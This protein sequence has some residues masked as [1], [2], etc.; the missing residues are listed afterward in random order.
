MADRGTRTAAWSFTFNNPGNRLPVYDEATMEYLVF[1]REI[2]PETGTPH[3]QGYVRFKTRIFMPA[4]LRRLGLEGVHVEPARGTE[5]QNRDY[6]TKEESRDAGPW[7]FGNFSADAGRRGTRSDLKQATDLIRS[8][9]SMKQVANAHPETFVR[10]FAG[11]QAL[12]NILVEPPVERPVQILVLWGPTGTGKTH[13]VLTNMELRSDGGLYC[14]PTAWTSHPFD[15]YSAESTFFL[16]EFRWENWPAVELNK[17]LD[18]WTYQLQCRY[19][20]KFAL[21]TRVVI[22]SNQDPMSWYPNEDTEIRSAV[23]RRLGHSC[24]HITNREQ[25]ISEMEPSPDF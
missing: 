22:C 18:K 24:R 9:A 14:A 16:D 8:G 12:K 11:L 21:W 1:Q 3:L 19:M 20:N 15:A 17:I 7:E 6:C 4:V 10:S 13:R 5:Q 2:A 23:R 25:I